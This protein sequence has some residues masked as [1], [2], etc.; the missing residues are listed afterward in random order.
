MNQE[1]IVSHDETS[2]SRFSPWFPE[3]LYEGGS[4]ALKLHPPGEHSFYYEF[5]R[6]QGHS[7]Y[8]SSGLGDR[9]PPALRFGS[10]TRTPPMIGHVHNVATNVLSQ[11]ASA[12]PPDT[13]YSK[14]TSTPLPD[15]PS[16]YMMYET[17]TVQGEKISLIRHIT[18]HGIDV[19]IGL[20][21]T[22]QD[23]GEH[24]TLATNFDT[25][26]EIYSAA[27]RAAGFTCKILKERPDS[28]YESFAPALTAQKE[29]A[30]NSV[31][32]K[33]VRRIIANQTSTTV[34]FLANPSDVPH[35]GLSNAAVI[36]TPASSHPA[37]LQFANGF[38]G[39]TP[40][41]DTRHKAAQIVQAAIDKAAAYDIEA[42]ETDGALTFEF[43]L[44]NGYLVIGELSI[45]G[46]LHANVYNDQHP[47]TDAGIDEIWVKCLPQASPEDL[48]DLL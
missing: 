38:E 36:E 41:T 30:Y 35:T 31:I 11:L 5:F 8:H 39:E 18:A 14:F 46:D 21:S 45:K 32:T 6:N 19:S 10:H 13:A 24:W 43:R 40:S 28:P 48:T 9:E 20:S 47:D 29:S 23:L 2:T 44:T 26:T 12:D 15:N 22:P 37:I 4:I 7:V 34:L 16:A 17:G 25:G 27:S 33:L 42:D 3:R 1:M